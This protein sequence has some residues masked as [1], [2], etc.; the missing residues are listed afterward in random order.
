MPSVTDLTGAKMPV[1]LPTIPLHL[2]CKC[3][4]SEKKQSTSW[5][6]NKKCLDITGLLKESQGPMGSAD[7]MLESLVLVVQTFFKT[8]SKFLSVPHCIQFMN[9]PK[10]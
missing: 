8:S 5:Y 4:Y 1:V 7:C 9:Y 6:Y 2:Q 3:Q 10:N